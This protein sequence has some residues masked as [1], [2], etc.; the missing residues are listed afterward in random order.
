MC[1]PVP[2]SLTWAE[3][4]LKSVLSFYQIKKKE[5]CF[6][7]YIFGASTVQRS[8]TRNEDTGQVA[9][10]FYLVFPTCEMKIEKQLGY[11]VN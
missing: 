6:K 9:E 11:S 1:V 3:V 4:R 7:I 10:T 2:F 8:L 5:W